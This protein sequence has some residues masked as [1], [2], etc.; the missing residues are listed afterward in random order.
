VRPVH[1]DELVDYL[2]WTDQRE[3]ARPG[4]LAGKAVRRA[5]LG[6]H[7]LL[8]FENRESVRYQV[9]EMMRVEQIV[10][11]RDIVHELHTY[12]ELLGGPGELGATVMIG[13]DDVALRDTLLRRWLGLQAHLY[14]GLADGTRVF[15][16]WDPRQVGDDRISS[17]QYLRFPVNGAVPVSFGCTFADELVGGEVPLPAATQAALAADLAD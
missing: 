16:T 14:L 3:A 2:T 11:E 7:L 15:A 10:R 12:N 1:R 8:L 13:V 9:Q 4:I 6:P 17:V 5:Q